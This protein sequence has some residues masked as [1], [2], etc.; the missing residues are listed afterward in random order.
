MSGI[1]NHKF[2]LEIGT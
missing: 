2:T 1:D